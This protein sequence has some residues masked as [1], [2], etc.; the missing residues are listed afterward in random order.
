VAHFSEL[1]RLVLEH[2]PAAL[3]FA[4]RMTDDRDAAEELVQEAL[5]RVAQRWG[6]FRGEA[7]FRTWLIRILINVF[8][9]QLRRRSL[10]IVSLDEEEHVASD[11]KAREPVEIA[12]T[13]ELCERV[14]VAVS[15]LPPRQRE[16]LVLI[17]YEELSV[18][19]TAVLVG[20]TEQNVYATLSAARGQLKRRLAHDLG[21]AEK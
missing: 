1:D 17:V 2:L 12:A 19:E 4:V 14:A 10:A 16:V 3:R 13:G 21:F 15:R 11:P 9:D 18:A 8:R 20:I 7:T 6:A 5:V